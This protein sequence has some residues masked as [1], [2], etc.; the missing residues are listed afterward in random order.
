MLIRVAD[1]GLGIPE[2][3]HER[4]F[5]PFYSTKARG[6]GLGLALVRDLVAAHGGTIALE[7]APNRGTTF[8]ILLPATE[9]G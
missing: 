5:T 2:N 4:I 9:A 8:S 7:S 3:D 1:S 6:T